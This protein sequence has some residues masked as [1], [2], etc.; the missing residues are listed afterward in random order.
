MGLHAFRLRRWRET[1]GQIAQLERLQ[2]L[3][4]SGALTDSEFEREK[5][6]VLAES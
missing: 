3:R 5:A 2:R 1:S 6:K 4:E